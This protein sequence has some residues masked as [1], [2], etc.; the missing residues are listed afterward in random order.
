M[1]SISIF[2]GSS[3]GFDPAYEDMAFEVG[4]FFARN[5]IT[6]VYG[7]ARVGLMGA[8]ADGALSKNGKVIGVLPGFL[9]NKEL[10]H[11]GISKMIRVDSMHERKIKMYELSDAC[12]ALPGGFGTID[13][14]FEILTWAQLGLHRK[15]AGL[16]NFK[17]YFD[18]L[19]RFIDGMVE[20]GF[21][22]DLNKSIILEDKSMLG[23][24]DK[25]CKYKPV[26]VRKWIE[27]D[28]I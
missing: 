21:L 19:I 14:F 25:I 16:L 22:K 6:V 23:L 2:C 11:S 9:N 8:I 28:E 4:Q 12:I 20:A 10:A 5:Q 26:P 24:Y 1:N 27:K 15:P 7:G 18:Y 17:G 13:E 3:S